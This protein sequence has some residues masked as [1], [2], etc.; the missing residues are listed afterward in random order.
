[1]S[2]PVT[3][4][5]EFSYRDRKVR[6][7]RREEGDRPAEPRSLADFAEASIIVL[8]GEPG[9]GKTRS[10]RQAAGDDPAAEYLKVSTFFSDPLNIHSGK[11]LFL[12]ALDEYRAQCSE[13]GLALNKLLGK[14]KELNRP[15]LRL[16]CRSIDWQDGDAAKLA[17]AALDC[18]V[19]VVDLL[20]LTDDDI[21]AM[22][23]ERRGDPQQFLDDARVR[24][25][26]DLLGNPELLDLLL[27][28]YAPQRRW[29]DSRRDL[30]E[31][32]LAELMKETNPEHE[33]EVDPPLT[34]AAA[35]DRLMAIALLANR[36]GFAMR[37]T[38]ADD[39]FAV[40]GEAG[41]DAAL[42]RQA[43]GRRVFSQSAPGKVEPRH[44]TV[45]EFMA[46]RHLESRICA[47]TNP[48]PLSR[49]LALLTG[50]DGGTF[51]DTRGVFA[52][53]ATL[54]TGDDAARLAACDPLGAVLYGDAALWATATKVA[55]FDALRKLAD[56]DPW[57][58]HHE[59]RQ[60]NRPDDA[61]FGGLACPE[62][63][64]DFR[65]VLR[66]DSRHHLVSTVL[67]I[68]KNGP[69]L[70]E[71]GD[72]LLDLARNNERDVSLRRQAVDAFAKI[73][74][75][76][77]AALV[78]VLNDVRDKVVKDESFR[79]RSLLLRCL[80]P[81]VI[82]PEALPDYLVNI[83]ADYS[84]GYGYFLEYRLVP[85][86]PRDHLVRL[87]E[88]L[89]ERKL[90]ADHYA[91]SSLSRVAGGLLNR[92][93]TEVP[94]A[95]TPERLWRRLGIGLDEDGKLIIKQDD[96]PALFDLL[97][98]GD[99]FCALFDHWF[100]CARTA[101]NGRFYHFFHRLIGA[102]WPPMF[103]THVLHRLETA[104]DDIDILLD[105]AIGIDAP[106][107]GMFA[108]AVLNPI[109]WRPLQQRMWEEA[110]QWRWEQAERRAEQRKQQAEK[111][112]KQIDD[113]LAHIDGV[114]SGAY[115]RNLKNPAHWWLLQNRTDGSSGREFDERMAPYGS[116]ITDAYLSGFKAILLRDD[117]PT[118]Q[119][120]G[121]LAVEGRHYYASL[122]VQAGM[123]L[124]A[125]AGWENVPLLPEATLRA[126]ICFAVA[127]HV[128]SP[129]WFDRLMRERPDLAGAALYEFWRASFEA[130]GA[131]CPNGLN[132]QR[133]AGTF[134]GALGSRARDLLQEFPGANI[135]ALDTLLTIAVKLPDVGAALDLIRSVLEN[136]QALS[137]AAAALWAAAG[138]RLDSDAFTA[139]LESVLAASPKADWRLDE[140]LI[141]LVVG[142]A[143]DRKAWRLFIRRLTAC[144]GYV[145]SERDGWVTPLMEA[146]R[147][148]P[149]YID[150]LA[151]DPSP[152]TSKFLAEMRDDPA[153]ASWRDHFAHAAAQQAQ[154]RRQ[155]EYA[156]PNVAEVVKTLNGGTPANIGDL[157]A[158]TMDLLEDIKK[159]MRDGAADGW[160]ACWNTNKYGKA[161][162][163]KIENDCRDF[164]LGHLTSRLKPFGATAKPEGR[165]ADDKRAD[166]DVTCTAMVLPI[167]IKRQ[168][169][170]DI[171]AAPA[172]QLDRQ[173]ARD[174]A[175]GRRG[176]YLAFW[177]G[178]EYALK[179]PP[180][181]AAKP[182]TAA[183]LQDALE[184]HLPTTLGQR[185]TVI[186]FDVAKPEP[187]PAKPG[188]PRRQRGQQVVDHGGV[189][190]AGIAAISITTAAV[191]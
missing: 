30:F 73:A 180:D 6:E 91:V 67:D 116:D 105:I 155:A 50:G 186:V 66:D 165:Y 65:Q 128:G 164:L 172:D 114:R 25:L 178:Q 75:D 61:P 151:A 72:D 109:I 57:F 119:E 88:A 94:D 14:F 29:P 36:D 136:P 41:G 183:E 17:E 103:T 139:T 86:T 118:P 166:I 162:D 150:I 143:D 48:L 129:D 3:S 8:L 127:D 33:T 144:Y 78:E 137:P 121:A 54:L 27:I 37:N 35:A 157:Q 107:E 40:I 49:V 5:T 173:Y 81:G 13:K 125:Q 4:A 175:A 169:H 9:L 42:M 190:R 99:I 16:S 161:T 55:T 44:R 115:A 96:A 156:P 56:R 28:A 90:S 52:W 51:P 182:T 171:W 80:Y 93:V 32:A 60:W 62:L 163:P 68:L 187:A 97:S 179:P 142:G 19:A 131:A 12:D 153:R 23:G 126:A 181:R 170:D 189:H 135:D 31:R 74:P 152:E 101:G 10:F 85:D 39:M 59:N 140:R 167:E 64:P 147:I 117:L 46:A 21:L 108:A 82:T 87:A 149:N 7:R 47:D 2:S 77:L 184:K 141:V 176:V 132:W 160:K 20:P 53:L 191:Q 76:R 123:A 104:A 168:M 45:A 133:A 1:M 124:T 69:A 102:Q 174:P 120:I 188:E 34:A 89:V 11:T 38:Q 98:Q 134:L 145:E 159:E 177:F 130:D 158:L 111:N 138:Y 83:G 154:R 185:I 95:I 15:K 18:K 106:L 100:D 63:V 70:P 79:L 22:V 71:L 26:G 146:L 58:R 43:A 113:I 24:G 112:R 92:I 110:P 148:I 122:P 84:G